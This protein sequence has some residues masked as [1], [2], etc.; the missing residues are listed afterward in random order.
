MTLVPEQRKQL[1]QQLRNNRKALSQKQQTL[2]S[3]AL[4]HKCIEFAEQYSK[5]ALYLHND[6]EINPAL[7]IEALWNLN[8]TVCLPVMH[9]FRKGYLNFQVYQRDMVLPPNHY[10][11]PEPQLS[12]PHTIAVSDIDVLFM[13]LVGFDKKGNRLGMGGGYYDR[14]LNRILNQQNRPILI[15]LAHDCQQVDAL[16]IESWDVPLDI[17]LTP[18]Q[19]IIINSDENS[20]QSSL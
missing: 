14:T 1:R 15:G 13:P 3:E 4:K 12:A 6:G 16:P 9:S 5:F 10:G 8:K 2:A 17:I 19:K 11:I 20:E 7:A 18:T